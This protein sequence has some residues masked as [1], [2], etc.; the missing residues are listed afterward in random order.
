M[1]NGAIQNEEG[2]IIDVTLKK[3]KVSKSGQSLKNV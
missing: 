2:L 1:E 3:V